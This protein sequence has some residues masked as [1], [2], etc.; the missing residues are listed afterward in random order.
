MDKDFRN[1]ICCSL[2]TSLWKHPFLLTKCIFAGSFCV[3][4]ANPFKAPQVD[5]HEMFMNSLLVA[6]DVDSTMLKYLLSKPRFLAPSEDVQNEKVKYFLAPLCTSNRD[7]VIQGINEIIQLYMFRELLWRALFQPIY[8]RFMILCLEKDTQGRKLPHA[9]CIIRSALTKMYENLNMYPTFKK[10][11]REL[12]FIITENVFPMDPKELCPKK[13]PNT[14]Q[15]KLW[16][17]VRHVIILRNN[18]SPGLPNLHTPCVGPLPTRGRK[19]LTQVDMWLESHL[20]QLVTPQRLHLWVSIKARFL[21]ATN[22]V[23]LAFQG[24]ALAQGYFVEPWWPQWLFAQ[25]VIQGP[26]GQS[27]DRAAQ[28]QRPYLADAALAVHQNDTTMRNLQVATIRQSDCG[29]DRRKV[30][31]DWEELTHLSGVT[32][33]Y[34]EKMNQWMAT[35]FSKSAQWY[36]TRTTKDSNLK[37]SIDERSIHNASEPERSSLLN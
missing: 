7:Q 27:P 1:A 3:G 17:D 33:N 36:G 34:N 31:G 8:H 30:R 25:A 18:Q 29:I 16:Q 13:D 28:V 9:Y 10:V 37:P 21:Y 14:S 4:M 11:V 20:D 35:S 32:Y 6:I 15:E 26:N 5:Q 19:I 22:K 12:P 24:W 23:K 2:N